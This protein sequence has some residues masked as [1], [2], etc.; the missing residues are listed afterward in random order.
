MESDFTHI[1]L[2]HDEILLLV[3][4]R[5]ENLFTNLKLCCSEALLLVLNH[6]FNGGLSSE[7][8]MQLGAG[9]C[10]GMGEAGCTC[11]ALSGAIMGMGLL[12]GPHGKDGLSKK[13]FRQ[14][15]K[16]MLDRF[17]EKFSSTCCRTLIKDFNRN[18]KARMHF[19][20]DLTAITA[21][22]AVEL[23][24]EAQPDL[25]QQI[26]VVYLTDRDSKLSGLLGKLK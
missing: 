18:S 26:Q 8:A 12:V 13:K 17:H 21:E 7:Q 19:C 6:G 20:A 24:L 10:G 16:K 11:G 1:S 23:L 2:Q 5:A 14:L 9:F 3:K 25:I 22:I 4:Q 15:A